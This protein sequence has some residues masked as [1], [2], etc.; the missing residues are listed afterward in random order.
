MGLGNTFIP[1]PGLEDSPV[2]V[3]QIEA[4]ESGFTT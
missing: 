4:K 2:D 1:C 3:M